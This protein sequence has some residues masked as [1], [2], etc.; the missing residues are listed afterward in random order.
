MLDHLQQP[1][2]ILSKFKEKEY[3]EQDLKSLQTQTMNMDRRTLLE[4][5]PKKQLEPK[6]IAFL[7]N[8][9][10]DYKSNFKTLATVIR[11]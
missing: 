4:D 5:K 8:L 2:I 7:T 3:G 9:S 1:E 6:C 10:R 11:R